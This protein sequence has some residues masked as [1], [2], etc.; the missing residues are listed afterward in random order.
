MA[1][2]LVALN[3]ITQ[4]MI[5]VLIAM[6]LTLV[7]SIMHIIN[8]AHGELYMLGAFALWLLYSE[9]HINY[10]LALIVSIVL[11]F[12][13]GLIMERFFFRPVRAGGLF[14]SFIVAVGLVLCLQNLALIAF[15]GRDKGVPTAIPGIMNIYGV[16]YPYEK[17]TIVLGSAALIAGLFFFVQRV[18]MGK[19][20]RAVAQ[21]PDA[22][23]LQGISINQ[24]SALCLGIGAA[25]AAAAAGLVT[26]I[27]FI[28]P[29]MG[30]GMLMK[31]FIIIILGGMGSIPGAVI[32]GLFLGLMEGYGTYFFGAVEALIISFGI[33]MLVLIVRPTGLMG[34]VFR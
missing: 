19:A 20:M 15:S 28:N 8:F 21:D 2:A 3:G 14:P 1:L 23:V 16:P 34:Q 17:L 32:G 30:G 29:Y 12:I 33:I 22:A 7:F 18:R 31:A 26:P 11:L 27:L 5:Y 10:L 13:L 25:L 6:G 24:T 4:G 9:F